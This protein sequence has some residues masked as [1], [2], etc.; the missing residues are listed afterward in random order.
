MQFLP[1]M[2]EGFANK[3]TTPTKL[4][5]K[6]LPNVTKGPFTWSRVPGSPR[7]NLIERLYV[8]T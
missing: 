3:S 1:S 5:L 7:G 8:K 4:D 6:F 2:V